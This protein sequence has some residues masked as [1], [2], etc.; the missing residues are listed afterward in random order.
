MLLM[1][2]ELPL[3]ANGSSQL[4]SVKTQ[5]IMSENI[6]MWK[7]DL[8]KPWFPTDLPLCPTWL[9][10]YVTSSPGS[11][12]FQDN[13]YFLSLT[14]CSSQTLQA[15]NIL[16]LSSPAALNGGKEPQQ[17]SQSRQ[18]HF[19]LELNLFACVS[20]VYDTHHNDFEVMSTKVEFVTTM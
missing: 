20:V 7:V 15:P 17:S 11:A 16:Q 4:S 13:T 6:S 3:L 19:T 18:D 14:F 8:H 5:V 1:C 9:P 12:L 10:R 2:S